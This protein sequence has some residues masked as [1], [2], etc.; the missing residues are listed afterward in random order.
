M[1][2]RQRKM[3]TIMATCVI[4]VREK[5]EV[6]RLEKMKGDTMDRL[7]ATLRAVTRQWPLHCR[8]VKGEVGK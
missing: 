5:E 4:E 7:D 3:A 1:G 6:Q 8:Q 2:G